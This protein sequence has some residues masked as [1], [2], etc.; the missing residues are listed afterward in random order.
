MSF[1]F[2]QGSY[3]LYRGPISQWLFVLFWVPIKK[4]QS[5]AKKEMPP[6]C[7]DGFF[8]WFLFYNQNKNK[9]Q[10]MEFP[11]IEPIFSMALQELGKHPR[12]SLLQVHFIGICV[13][14]KQTLKWQMITSG[15]KKEKAQKTHTLLP[16]QVWLK[17]FKVRH[18]P[19]P[20]PDE[21]KPFCK[22]MH[23]D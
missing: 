13:L 12:Y 19:K 21:K 9:K 2:E 1:F 16:P 18:A 6:S 7:E 14:F 3:N 17:K 4:K 8:S 15:P 5:P 10:G 11:T 23:C 22:I 20:I